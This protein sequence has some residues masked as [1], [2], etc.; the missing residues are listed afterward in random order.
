METQ[1]W[2]GAVEIGLAQLCGRA[3]AQLLPSSC[4]LAAIM[5]WLV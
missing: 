5:S 3:Y 4:L 1:S 2:D